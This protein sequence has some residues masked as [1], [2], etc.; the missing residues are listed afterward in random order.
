MNGGIEFAND[1]IDV[2]SILAR[3]VEIEPLNNDQFLIVKE[4]LTRI[5][6][7]SRDSK[8][9]TQSC[10]VLHKRGRYYIAHFKTLFALDGKPSNFDERDAARQNTIATLLET[11]GLVK[12]KSGQRLEEFVPTSSIKIV[13]SSEREEW[14]LIAK[15]RIGAKKR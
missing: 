1:E 7:P 12:I 15:H 4:T 8:T 2:A 13:H 5:G 10:H 11:W 6:V 9:L 14:N 3:M